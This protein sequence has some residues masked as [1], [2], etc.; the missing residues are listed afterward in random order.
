[1]PLDK[2]AIDEFKKLYFREYGI[3]LSDNEAYCMGT[4]LVKFVK[5]VLGP[6]M[7]P[8]RLTKKT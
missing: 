6:D 7:P 3:E 5:A 4:R 8:P 1:M 2:D